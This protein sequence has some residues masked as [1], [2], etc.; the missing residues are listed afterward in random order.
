MRKNSLPGEKRSDWRFHTVED[1]S[2]VWQVTYADGSKAASENKFS[3]VKEC[4][5]DATR[6]GYVSWI[7]EAERRAAFVQ[8]PAP[9]GVERRLQDRG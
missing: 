5:A 6:S 8:A 7:P 1:R 3:T 4:V 9:K 2:W